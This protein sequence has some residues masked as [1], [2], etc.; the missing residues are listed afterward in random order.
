MSSGA[1]LQQLSRVVEVVSV[2]SYSEVCSEELSLESE[3]TSVL[4]S[5]S[6]KMKKFWGYTQNFF[7]LPDR[8]SRTDVNSD[9]NDNS[10]EHTSEYENTLTTSTTRDNCC[11]AAPDDI[12]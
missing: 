12:P 9:S 2:F 10:S 5:L 7:I 11:K 1:A 8:L 6:G 3:F 4:D